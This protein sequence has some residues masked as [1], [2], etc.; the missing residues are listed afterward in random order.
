MGLGGQHEVDMGRW[1]ELGLGQ[2]MADI[3]A[4]A[5]VAVGLIVCLLGLQVWRGVLA[6][7]GFAAG[8]AAG[9]SLAT[10]HAPDRPVVV[11]GLG[12]ASGCVLMVVLAWLPRL[13]TCVVFGVIG[14]FVGRLLT[15]HDQIAEQHLPIVFGVAG[16]LLL[17]LAPIYFEIERPTIV[18][19]SSLGGAWAAVWG[20]ALFFG[21]DFHR[22]LDLT[23]LLLLAGQ[24]R[25][26]LTAVALLAVVGL[27]IQAAGMAKAGP[28]PDDVC[29][30]M[31]RADLPTKR[32]VAVLD[33][34]SANNLITRTEYYRH[35][36]R[37]LLSGEGVKARHASPEPGQRKRPDGPGRRMPT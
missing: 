25:A 9:I 7:V 18:L 1:G 20:A 14:W 6:G 23:G 26:E 34:L 24:F 33:D 29:E 15:G 36:V 17:G 21:L 27:V 8:C 16:V 37:V 19:V 2:D 12:V 30:A 35:L 10:S 22:T 5:T 28:D 31:S 32:R 4:A 13:G 11:I 3:L